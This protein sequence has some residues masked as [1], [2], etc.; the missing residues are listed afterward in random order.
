MEKSTKIKDVI[1]ESLIYI[2]WHIEEGVNPIDVSSEMNYPID[3]FSQLFSEVTRMELSEY[4]QLRTLIEARKEWSKTK[5]IDIIAQK[6]NQ[7]PEQ[8]IKNFKDKF[9]YS[10]F[11]KESTIVYSKL[12]GEKLIASI[13]NAA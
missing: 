6:Y 11:D 1:V 8:L 13:S 12:I 5:E 9:G 4:L 10:F 3:L 7:H 2:E